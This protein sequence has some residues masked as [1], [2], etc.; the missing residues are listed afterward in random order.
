MGTGI[1]DA[2]AEPAVRDDGRPED[3]G[4]DGPEDGSVDDGEVDNVSP[5]VVVEKAVDTGR[6]G[7]VPAA[8]VT[9]RSVPEVDL[10]IAAA[11]MGAPWSLPLPLGETVLDG[12]FWLVSCCFS[13]SLR[14]ATPAPVAPAPFF[15]R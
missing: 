4:P 1:E 11:A 8:P 2:T 9:P 13:A 10:P 5:A 7:I 6:R 3:E 12:W 14:A 15:L